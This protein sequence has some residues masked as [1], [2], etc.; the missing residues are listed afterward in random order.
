MTAHSEVGYLIHMKAD[1]HADDDEP[2]SVDVI[3]WLRNNLLHMHDMASQYACNWSAR[4]ASDAISY[5]GETWE[6]LTSV[7]IR[8]LIRQDGAPANIVYRVAAAISVSANS[9]L[10][11]NIVPLNAPFERDSNL[12]YSTASATISS[13]AVTWAIEKNESF[14][15]GSDAQNDLRTAFKNATTWDDS[16]K[17]T[18][19]QAA[20]FIWRLD[21]WG[22]GTDEDALVVHAV[23]CRQY[24]GS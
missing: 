21:L 8:V 18:P 5:D 13:T 6:L 20:L 7:P 19:G 2:L 14:A 1:V 12:A 15:V 3:R 16:S 11:A 24:I 10:Q 17:T 23:Q 22:K 9:S 4:S